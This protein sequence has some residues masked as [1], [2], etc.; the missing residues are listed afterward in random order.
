MLKHEKKA[1][2]CVKRYPGCLRVLASNKSCYEVIAYICSG[3]IAH[4]D[5]AV[6]AISAGVRRLEQR[7][8][9]AALTSLAI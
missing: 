5:S 3:K 9:R 2:T 7:A 1:Y 6:Q 8:R 4:V